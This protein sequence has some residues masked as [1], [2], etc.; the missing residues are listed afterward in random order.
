MS[1][2]TDNLISAWELDEASGNAVD[3]FGSNTL[4]ETSGTIEAFAGGGRDIELGDSEWFEC[5]SNASLVTGD[6][7]FTIA[8]WVR[9]ESLPASVMEIAC[10]QTATGTGGEYLIGW[11]GSSRF[12]FLVR[13]AAD[14]ANV[15]RNFTSLGLP[16]VDTWY[17]LV[18]WHDSVGN[19]LN[20]QANNGVVDT[21][22]HTTGVFAGTAKFAIGN[23]DSG[24]N[25]WD[26]V[27]R[28]VRFWK[29]V[30]TANE[31][32]W[33]YNTGVGRSIQQIRTKRSPLALDNLRLRW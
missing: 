22:A 18:A 21:T 14:S 33:L 5:D 30:L 20:V 3:S 17:F 15:A 12:R 8:A 13:N 1:L 10:K 11:D 28:R 23:R 25:Y 29:R 31:R 32:T 6:I 27:I 4:T 24:T 9:A 26:G 2:L 19:T 7:D 16:V